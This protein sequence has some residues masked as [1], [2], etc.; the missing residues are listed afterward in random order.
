[1]IGYF[2]EL[3]EDELLYSWFARYYVHIGYT[4][5]SDAYL[6]LYGKKNI[7][8]SVELVNNMLMEAKEVIEKY[9]PMKEIILENTMF[10]EYGRFISASRRERI[11]SEC[12][13]TIGNWNNMLMVPISNN[14]RV[15]KYCPVCAQEDR[16]YYGETYWHKSHQISNIKICNKHKL[17]L[18]DSIVMIDRNNT[19]LKAA[20]TAIPEDN[21]LKTCDNN[22]ILSLCN[23]MINVFYNNNYSHDKI[24]LTLSDRIDGSYIHDNGDRRLYSFY[25]AYV[26]YYS[27]LNET[28]LMSI[29]Y[30]SKLLRGGKGS[31]YYI[32][33]LGLF[34]GIVVNELLTSMSES[35]EQKIFRIVSANLDEPIELVERIGAAVINECR[36][37]GGKNIRSLRHKNTI[38]EDDTRLLQ[39]VKD[40]CAE[41]Y[42]YDKNRPRKVSVAAV[43]KELSI[44]SHRLKRM[45]KCMEIISSYH[46][47]QKHYWARE[48]VWAVDMIENNNNVLNYRHIRDLINLK[49]ENII[50]SLR[51]L[52]S[53]DEDVYKRVRSLV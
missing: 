50:D 26:S 6:D 43:S 39:S 22:I 14:D 48:I 11:L 9:K 28:E 45:A 15:L 52:Q 25:D 33:Q 29:D 24:G 34:E 19:R 51:E 53:I 7:R 36:N 1:M 27:S 13:F 12:D 18:L 10:P 21:A 23:Y 44:D 2:P 3:Y 4:S 20:E 8:P 49:P 41:I 32:C 16:N 46:E 42:G 35:F 17:F 30:M 40:F 37:Y 5:V 31:F 38:E 47:T